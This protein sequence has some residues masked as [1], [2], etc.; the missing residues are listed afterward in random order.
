MSIEEVV[1][2]AGKCCECGHE[3]NR[4]TGVDGRGEP[5]PGD[6]SLCVGCASLNVF[7]ADLKV[8][9]PTEEEILK[10][11][12]DPEVQR[13]RRLLQRIPKEMRTPETAEAKA[14]RE[15]EEKAAMARMT[16]Y[17]NAIETAIEATI[18]KIEGTT[19]V[20][21]EHEMLAALAAISARWV[22][23]FTHLEGH[24]SSLDAFKRA[25]AGSL[26]DSRKLAAG[27]YPKAP[28][29]KQQDTGDCDCVF[30]TLRRKM[31]G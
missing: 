18:P 25:F 1:V 23:L 12:A 7:G 28:G 20:Q 19:E 22:A 5:S 4:A 17:T 16:R 3:T 31:G 24:D 8:R 21:L 13:A 27:R 14:A 26:K 11:A 30:C 29:A 15:A 9:A 10:A 2:P 6:F